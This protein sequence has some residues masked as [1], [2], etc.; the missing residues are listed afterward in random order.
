[1]YYTNSSTVSKPQKWDPKEVLGLAYDSYCIGWATTRGRQCQRYIARHKSSHGQCILDKLACE[2]ASKAAESP[3]LPE[4]LDIMLCWQ[5][6]GQ[7]SGILKKWKYKL[8]NYAP[9]FDDYS[10]D[11]SDDESSALW[12]ESG[13]DDWRPKKLYTKKEPTSDP[14]IEELR[15]MMKQ[16]QDNLARLESELR[17]RGKHDIKQ[18]HAKMEAEER[19]K[20]E[21]RRKEEER[22]RQEQA[23]RQEEEQKRQEEERRRR[24]EEERIRKEEEQRRAE[25]AREDAFRERVR[26]AKKRRE[27]EARMKAEKEAA[28]WKAT[29]QRYSNAWDKNDRATILT[30]PWPVKSGLQID[31]TEA[32]VRLFFAKAPPADFVDSGEKRFKFI[33]AENKR[34]HT[35]K[36]IQRFG[37]EL[38]EGDA[39]TTLDIIAKVVIELRQ[40]AQ[41][42][43]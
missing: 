9:D 37:R 25:K 30:I 3:D 39:K 1:M 19:Q 10:N 42:E 26:L 12:S 24:E 32:N 15:K 36:V 14:S 7:S 34:W 28:E 33:N 22:I 21:A 11:D 35:D 17:R 27:E 13:L 43:R 4:A 20:R 16:M 5:H 18:D 38:V 6:T 29:W 40:E 2:N 31:V 23:R 41:R 8:E